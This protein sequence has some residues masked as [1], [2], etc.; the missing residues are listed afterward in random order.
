AA[1]AVLEHA[2]VRVRVVEQTVC[3]GLPL[4]STGQLDAARNHLGETVAALDA[5]GDAPIV[6]V[7][8]SC[9]ATLAD[10]AQKLLA[11]DAAERVG[12]RVHTLA[13]YLLGIG[14][15]LPDLA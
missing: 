6:G 7:E 13:D 10:D 12:S 9:L 14:A 3:C 2:G 8:P 11:S 5:T 1:V 4:I 15:E